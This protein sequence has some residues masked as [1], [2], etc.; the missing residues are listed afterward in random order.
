MYTKS[1][2]E[3]VD[4]L[5]DF[6]TSVFTSEDLSSVPQIEKQ[7]NEPF[8]TSIDITEEITLEILNSLNPSKSIGPD[9]IHPRI[10]KETS[11]ILANPLHLVFRSSLQHGM[12]PN[13]WKIAH[14]TPLHK[15]GSK[16]SKENY[17]PL[18]QSFVGS[19]KE[20]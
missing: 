7:V 10:L 15:K 6:F 20:Y 12:I 8:L 3:K 9:G 2:Q 19:W 1:E 17:R 5:N 13:E 14:V 16:H 4:L 11:D 18:R